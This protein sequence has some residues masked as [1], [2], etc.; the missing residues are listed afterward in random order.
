MMSTS[1]KV[2]IPRNEPV[3]SCAPGSP[4]RADFRYPFVCPGD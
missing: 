1:V 2:P 3:L 4:E